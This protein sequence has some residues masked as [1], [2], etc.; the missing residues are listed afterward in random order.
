MHSGEKP[1]RCDECAGVAFRTYGMYK[2]HLKTVHNSIL[3]WRGK[4]PMSEEEL[5]SPS[6]S[7]AAGISSPIS[8]ELSLTSTNMIE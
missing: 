4:V 8:Q 5:A 7:A 2:R 1:F 3:T 6:T